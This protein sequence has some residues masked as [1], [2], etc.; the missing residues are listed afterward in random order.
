MPVKHSLP[1]GQTRSWARDQ[2]VL[3]PTTKVPLDGT[4]E[5]PQLRSHLARGP[6]LEGAAPSRKEG[7]GQE[8]QVPFQE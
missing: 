8:D 4:A 5:V 1:T 2:A 7:E 3:T 6:S